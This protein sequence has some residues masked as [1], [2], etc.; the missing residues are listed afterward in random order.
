M[1]VAPKFVSH[2]YTAGSK[3][4]KIHTLELYADF[5]CPFSAKMWK[6]INT[7][8]IPYLEEKKPGQVEI[9]FR[10]LVQPWHP[11]ST[12]GMHI[13]LSYFL[14]FNSRFCYF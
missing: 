12:L 3:S 2:I 6:S 1:A 13:C 10:Q 5:V 14:T 8:V 7:N 4:H 9:I 11:S